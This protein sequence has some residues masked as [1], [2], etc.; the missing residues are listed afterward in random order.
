MHS[1]VRTV[2]QSSR[3]PHWLRRALPNDPSPRQSVAMVA[4]AVAAVIVLIAVIAIVAT[5]SGSA[6][7]SPQAATGNLVP[8]ATGTAPAGAPPTYSVGTASS[9]NLHLSA[10]D[11][12]NSSGLPALNR[13]PALHGNETR[14][15]GQPPG[16]ILLRP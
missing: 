16:R 5:G 11:C 6:N 1:L 15:L 4:G 7:P 3:I 13:R 12:F 2:S 8:A 10:A 14:G 9:P